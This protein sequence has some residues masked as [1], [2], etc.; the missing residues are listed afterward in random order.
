M[1]RKCLDLTH[2]L[3]CLFYADRYEIRGTSFHY[4]NLNDIFKKNSLDTAG[5][6]LRSYL[7]KVR[8]KLTYISSNYHPKVA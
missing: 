4:K 8:K 5:E 6:V 2:S 7:E 1:D 3:K